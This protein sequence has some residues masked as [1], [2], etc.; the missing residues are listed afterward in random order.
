M[1]GV[2]K[3]LSLGVGSFLLYLGAFIY[4]T[5]QKG[6][7][8]R[9][10]DWWIRIDDLNA[11]GLRLHAA[12]TVVVAQV[13]TA[14]FDAVFGSRLMSLACLG[15]SM[16][17]PMAEWALLVAMLRVAGLV[18][19]VGPATPIAVQAIWGA[20]LLVLANLR[21]LAPRLARAQFWLTIGAF[22]LAILIYRHNTRWFTSGSLKF[23]DVAE[24]PTI[25]QLI[26]YIAGLG[27]S[28]MDD[29]RKVK[30]LNLR[31]IRCVREW[32]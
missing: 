19:P 3:I 22:A 29:W 1:T 17:Y 21:P 10:E 5:E 13:T 30:G 6:L 27:L 31:P 4:E 8:N 18:H 24:P 12:F 32:F 16:A 14:C 23:P 25:D 15:A 26:I 7:Q 20:V 28:M 11:S 2:W 9:L